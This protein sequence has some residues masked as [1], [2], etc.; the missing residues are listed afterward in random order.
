[1]LFMNIDLFMDEFT[2]QI[3]LLLAL[4]E[5]LRCVGDTLLDCFDL[6]YSSSLSFFGVLS[7]GLC[8]IA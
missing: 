6:E 8:I 1:M 5:I 2:L 3:S 4:L 7:P